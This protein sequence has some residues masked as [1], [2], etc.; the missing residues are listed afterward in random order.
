MHTPKRHNEVLLNNN[1]KPV[2]IKKILEVNYGKMNSGKN[3]NAKGAGCAD[4]YPRDNNAQ[5]G[6]GRGGRGIGRGGSSKVWRR[7][8]ATEPS[9]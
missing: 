4:P 6:K 5:R 7:D 9:G 3:P 2:G 1:A 8:G